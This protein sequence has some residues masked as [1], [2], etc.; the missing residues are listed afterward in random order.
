[1]LE[2][3]GDPDLLEEPLCPERGGQVGA[4][5]LQGHLPLM[6]DI[7]GKK[8]RGHPAG[9]HLALDLVAVSEGFPQPNGL[10]LT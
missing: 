3:R 6:A 10:T 4:E 5:D 8:D 2:V 1:V 9:P 7:P